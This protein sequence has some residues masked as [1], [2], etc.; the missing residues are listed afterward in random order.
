MRLENGEGEVGLGGLEAFAGDQVA[1]A[2]IRDGERVT[3][4]LVTE[5]DLALVVGTPEAV[6]L[7]GGD[8]RGSFGF[9]TPSLLALY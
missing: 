1:G 7:V 3:V 8:Q 5:H 6:R 2:V 4:L 9:M